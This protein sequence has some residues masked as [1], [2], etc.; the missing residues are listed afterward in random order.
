MQSNFLFFVIRR[1]IN[2]FVT[3]ILLIVVVFSL[4]HII[5]PTPDA[6][7]RVYTGT[8][9]VS[10]AEVNSII[11]KYGLNKPIYVQFLSYLVNV[12]KGNFGI[13]SIYKVPETI[14]LEKFIPITLELVIAGLLVQLVLG[15]LLGTVAAM[16]RNRWHDW[17]IKV[18][19]LLT[20]AA[21]V[22][23]IATL[24]QFIFAYY[25]GVLPALNLASPYLV[26]PHVMTGFPLIDAA[27]QG[28]WVYF[29]SLLQHLILPVSAI[30]LVGFGLTT[31]LMRASMIETLDKDYVRLSYMKGLSERKVVFSTAFRNA[32]IPIITLTAIQFGFAVAG[33]V[34]VEDVFLYKGMGFFL[35][36]SITSLDFIAIL[37]TTLIIGISVIIA[38]F[39]ADILYGV[40]DPRVRL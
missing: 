7:A 15:I 17:L 29:D 19:Y 9:H 26:A 3:L 32:L 36:S 6:L 10:T 28:D 8:S 4:I 27:L 38:N 34:V 30:A 40:V 12:F 11:F 37:G 18:L 5:L 1:S 23:L 21:P 24:L 2:A 13:D 39:V 16:K 35:V 22:F 33:A 25:M 31:R 14:L 20:W